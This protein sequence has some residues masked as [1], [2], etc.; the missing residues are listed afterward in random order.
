MTVSVRRALATAGSRKAVMPLLTASTPVIAV[1]PLANAC[2]SSQRPTAAVAAGSGGGRDDRLRVAVAERPPCR[3]PTAS[4][5]AKHRDEEVGRERER[6][7][8]L[9][10]AAQVHQRDQRQDHQA[11]RQRVPVQGRERRDQ[12]GDAGGDPDRHVQ[13]VVDHQGRRRPEA[14]A[15]PEVLL[16][17]G[18]RTAAARDTRRWS[19]DR[20]GRGSPAGPRISQR[21]RRRRNAARPRPG[22]SGPSAAPRARRRPTPG[23]RGPAR[24]PPA[25][26]PIFCSDCSLLA[27][28][29]P[30]RSAPRSTSDTLEWSGRSRS[31]GGPA[32][33][34]AGLALAC[35]LARAALEATPHRPGPDRGKR[36]GRAA[37]GW[38]RTPEGRRSE[39]GPRGPMP[40]A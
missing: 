37:T 26:T 7:A 4:T 33:G 16:G 31:P 3:S 20:R 36:P 18:V 34:P 15:G 30:S 5:A 10:R 39:P 38:P 27:R 17:D 21:D 22:G 24:A 9:D 19:G 40:S 32:L 29:R 11:E 14:G 13:H 1:Q 6:P 25:R 8:R 28:R 23:R 35:P 12:R 2:S